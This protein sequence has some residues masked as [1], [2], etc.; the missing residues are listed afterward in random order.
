MEEVYSRVDDVVNVIL[1]SK[2]Y[3]K[4]ITLKNKM[5]T[6]KELTSKIEEIKHLQKEYIKASDNSIKER[7]DSLNNDLLQ[8]PIYKEYIDNLTI[9]N[10]YIDYVKE[11]LNDYFDKLLNNKKI[12][13]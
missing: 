11:S 3:K 13:S 5:S 12:N 4:C 6:N 10:N 7:L 9:V 8:I 2:E 1:N